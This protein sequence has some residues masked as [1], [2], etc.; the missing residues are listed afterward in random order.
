[1]NSLCDL[2]SG[3]VFSKKKIDLKTLP[4]QSLFYKDDIKI[5][6]KKAEKEDILEY[7]KNF[8]KDDLGLVIQKVKSIVEKNILVTGGYTFD[9]IKSIDVVFLF[10]EI[11]KLTKDKGIMVNYLDESSGKV[12]KIEF[13]QKNFNYFKI[14]EDVMKYYDSIS[15][16]FKMNGYSYTLPSIGVENC[17]TYYL[18]YKTQIDDKTDWNSVFFDFSY[19]VNDKSFLTYDEIENLIQ[20]FNH[21]IEEEEFEKIKNILNT[22]SPLQRYSLIKNGKLIDINSKI[23][24][25][26][27]WN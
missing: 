19:F 17:I 9:D 8:I 6:I 1:M 11:V 27:I 22:F 20:I 7:K 25:E 2:L 23:D 21:D 24:L 5:S 15:K 16:C 26:N 12:K 18:V 13:C 3:I 4:S 14:P 10:L